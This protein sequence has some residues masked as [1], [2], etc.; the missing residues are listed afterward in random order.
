MLLPYIANNPEY[1]TCAITRVGQN[2]ILT[3]YM[4]I[5]FTIFMPGIPYIYI[6]YMVLANP[7]YH[8]PLKSNVRHVT[9][10]TFEVKRATTCVT[11]A[12]ALL[13]SYLIMQ[14]HVQCLEQHAQFSEQHTHTHT[15][16]ATQPQPHTRIYKNTLHDFQNNAQDQS[17]MCATNTYTHNARETSH[18]LTSPC[19]CR[20]LQLTHL[21][22]PQAHTNFII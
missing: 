13:L 8:T 7:S 21:L 2:R 11:F 20:I 14:M 17:S 15:H 5:Y 18:L 6:Y 16:T 19:P 12:T 3:P 4:T 10:V 1:L 22:L 9:C